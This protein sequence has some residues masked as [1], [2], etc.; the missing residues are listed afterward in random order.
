MGSRDG[1][2]NDEKSPA[3]SS[4]F[5]YIGRRRNRKAGPG[6]V[7]EGVLP[8]C[9]NQ[10]KG[11]LM[12]E[13][14]NV[15]SK[16]AAIENPLERVSAV[17]DYV[18]CHYQHT[19]KEC[20]EL[21]LD[22]LITARSLGDNS[23]IARSLLWLG[24]CK[25]ALNEYDD[26]LALLLEADTLFSEMD[27]NAGRI[28]ALRRI[29][30]IHRFHGRLD[31]ALDM[32]MQAL[33]LA[34]I[35]SYKLDV[36]HCLNGLGTVYSTLG[37]Y[38]RAIQF[39]QRSLLL[40]EE[41]G[42]RHELGAIYIN[43]GNMYHRL[44][45]YKESLEYYY[46]RLALCREESNPSVEALTL[47]NIGASLYE[48][49]EFE[50]A[51]HYSRQALK[52]FE[53]VQDRAGKARCFVIM[54]AIRQTEERY[55]EAQEIFYQALEIADQIGDTDVQAGCLTNLGTLCVATQ[56]FGEAIELLSRALTVTEKNGS[57]KIQCE[58]YR[59]L[60]E[61]YE[62]AG[63][64]KR[65]LDYYKLYT[66][67]NTELLGR[68]KHMTIHE[69]QHRFYIEK[70]EQEK[71][72]YRLKNVELAQALAEVEKLNVNLQTMDTEK[73][74]LFGIVVH[75]LKSPLANIIMLGHLLARESEILNPGDI[76]EFASDILTTSNRMMELI[77]NL[78]DIHSME[79]GTMKFTEERFDLIVEIASVLYLYTER[80]AAKHIGL[81]VDAPQSVFVYTDR[82]AAIRVID[83]IVSNAVKYSPYGKNIHVHIE[84][85]NSVVR[86]SVRD[87]G[88]GIND[89]DMKKLF[90]KFA[91]LSAQPTG[92]EH[93]TG[94]GLSIVKKL[95]EAMNGVVW[96]EQVEGGGAK[97]V[98]EL[99]AGTQ[100]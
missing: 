75:D 41:L 34:E 1:L 8:G 31:E 52:L 45:N 79:S 16:I 67:L 23:S 2:W 47:Q 39:Y 66:N 25:L 15:H 56:D 59:Q 99:P 93:S 48:I 54:G 84:L 92:G 12:H 80:A 58:I 82:S 78:L 42:E 29:A 57:R 86:C 33:E 13:N 32:Y 53:K 14:N 95:V 61:V 49:E 24:R 10:V 21:V 63:D 26:A 36:A 65:A 27:D 71:E 76:R 70:L 88:P 40:R 91:R 72:I 7:F 94:L 19:P 46:K 28:Q 43:I 9:T 6:D 30:W 100:A 50:Q 87:E 64:G 83:N 90:G 17:L 74:D 60:A 81:Y 37:D 73:S 5:G 44:G 89:E 55:S 11:V 96:C 97:F 98:L 22:A 77:V 69:L 35:N 18:R 85:D 20:E 68:E 3:E 62:E 38:T 4:E 51:E